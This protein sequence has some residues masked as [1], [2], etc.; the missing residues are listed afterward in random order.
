VPRVY[1]NPSAGSTSTRSAAPGAVA[2]VDATDLT[3]VVPSGVDPGGYDVIVVNPDG[4]VGVARNA[5]QSL[6]DPPPAI[7]SLSPG[8]LAN[9]NP[10]ALTITGVNFRSPAVALACTDATGASTTAPAVSVSASTATSVSASV[11]ASGTTAVECVVTV[12]NADGS[13]ASYAAL[14]FTNPSLN[15]YPPIAGPDLGTPRRAPVL[16]GGDATATARFVHVLGGDDGVGGAYDTVETAPLSMFGAPGPYAVQRTRLSHARAFAG[17][18][19]IGRFLYVAGGSDVGVPL[20]TVERAAVL[21]PADRAL[22]SGVVLQ[23][24]KT[25][26]VGPGLWY[27]RV[28]AVHDTSDP[29]NPGGEDLPSDP[30]PVQLPSLTGA[31]LDVSVSWAPVPHAA[32]YRVYRSPAAGAT[33]G[34]EQVIAEVAAPATRF[35]DTGVSTPVSTDNPLPI[36]SLGAWTDLGA[37]LSVPREGPGVAWGLDPADPTKAYLYVLGGRKDASTALSSIEVLPIALNADGT[38]TPAGAFTLSTRSLSAARWQLGAAQA[39]SERSPNVPA[40]TTYVYALSGVSATGMAVANAEVATVQAGGDLSA[41]VPVSQL[42]R[43][44]YGV[45]VAGDYVFAF[46]GLQDVPDTTIQSAQISPTAPPALVNWNNEGV[47]MS[48]ARLLPGASVSGAFIYV[49]GGESVASPLGLT[50]RTQYFLW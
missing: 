7:A 49:A 22:L 6:A 17:G 8:A 14:V 38:Q 47:T 3:A 26:G 45:A 28:A 4:K 24:D 35:T 37:Q 50:P 36:G 33:V 18:A 44:G 43:A 34:T 20:A 25:A 40:G 30:F 31:R 12:T 1:L 27:Y 5:Y 41:P 46:G 2:L 16:L 42:H 32:R 39:T 19:L 10:Q 48:P 11:D 29:V 23:I 13:F 15:L 21:D 9:T